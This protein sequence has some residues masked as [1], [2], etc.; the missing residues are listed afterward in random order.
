MLRGASG[1]DS[2]GE[3]TRCDRRFCSES[4][5]AGVQLNMRFTRIG[6]AAICSVVMTAGSWASQDSTARPITS[7]DIKAEIG[8]DADARSVVA[9]VLT[10]L[11]LNHERREFFLA[12]QIRPE[13]LPSIP[14]VQFVRLA[15]T[16][17][18]KHISACGRYWLVDKVE[19]ADHVVSVMLNQR[20]G[21][22]S[23]RYIVSLEENE[24]RLGPPGSGKDGSGWTPG[25][26]SGFGGA[27]SPGCRCQ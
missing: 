17:V 7:N 15:D 11:M 12:S 18:L 6:V 8:T 20:C 13:W 22:T 26:G 21:G 16:D 5:S 27:P 1:V 19:R 4:T 24:W 3:E 9:Q 2:I 14:G 10:H 25:I 23:R